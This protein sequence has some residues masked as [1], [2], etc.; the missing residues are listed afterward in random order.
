MKSFQYWQLSQ[1]IHHAV[2]DLQQLLNLYLVIMSFLE[3]CDQEAASP[4]SSGLFFDC[5]EIYMYT[6][7]KKWYLT[8]LKKILSVKSIRGKFWTKK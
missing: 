5:D 2:C 6:E 1:S 4:N 7:E 8:T 3:L